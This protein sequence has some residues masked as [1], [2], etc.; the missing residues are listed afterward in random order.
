MPASASATNSAGRQE[1][2]HSENATAASTATATPRRSRR[3]GCRRR[4]AGRA[5]RSAGRR[6]SGRCRC[7]TGRTALAQRVRDQPAEADHDA[8]DQRPGDHQGSPA[9]RGEALRDSAA[10]S[11]RG[12]ARV[13]VAMRR[14]PAHAGAAV[15]LPA[16]R[17]PSRRL[18]SACTSRATGGGGAD[19]AA[20][21]CGTRRGAAGRAARRRA[22]EPAQHQ[23]REQQPEVPARRAVRAPDQA[24]PTRLT[25]HAE[26]EEDRQRRAHHLGRPGAGR[27]ARSAARRSRWRC[28]RRRRPRPAASSECRGSPGTCDGADGDQHGHAAPS[29][30][31]RPRSPGR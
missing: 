15:S 3:A 7:P 8:E 12:A 14:H 29:R 18:V 13:R 2:R 10:G 19:R 25:Q 21:R 22:S 28:R 5:R 1:R 4:R 9:V 24:S 11:R 6:T 23:R 17:L 27:A 20:R 26:E 16:A 31:S 30:R